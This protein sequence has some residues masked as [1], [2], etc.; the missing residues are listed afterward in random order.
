MALPGGGS[1]YNYGGF[2]F[3]PHIEGHGDMTPDELLDT[4]EQAEDEFMD[5]IDEW[6]YRRERAEYEDGNRTRGH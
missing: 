4:L 5:K 3:A 6:T 1:I 2:T